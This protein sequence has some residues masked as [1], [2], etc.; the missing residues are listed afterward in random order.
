[1]LYGR[2]TD[3][4]P[5]NGIESET[6]PFPPGSNILFRKLDLLNGCSLLNKTDW[7]STISTIALMHGKY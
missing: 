4:P 5:T 3:L 6:R 7:Q 1:M 2:F